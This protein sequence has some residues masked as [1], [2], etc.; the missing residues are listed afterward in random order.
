MAA[1][2]VRIR[3][4]HRPEPP[5]FFYQNLPPEAIALLATIPSRE[6]FAVSIPAGESSWR[7]GWPFAVAATEFAAGFVVVYKLQPDCRYAAVAVHENGRDYTLAEFIEIA[8]RRTR[9]RFGNIE[10]IPGRYVYAAPDKEE[11]GSILRDEGYAAINP[12]KLS[13]LHP[14]AVLPSGGTELIQICAPLFSGDKLPMREP[15]PV[16]SRVEILTGNTSGLENLR[17]DFEEYL[18]ARAELAIVPDV[19]AAGFSEWLVC[20][21]GESGFNRW[22]FRPVMAFGERTEWWG[23]RGRRRTVHEGLDFVEGF[24]RDEVRLIPEGVPARAIASGEVVA[25]LD[26]FMG[27]TIVV[28]HPSPTLSGGEVFHTILSHIQT[29]GSPPSFI[30]KGGML[31]RVGRRAGVRIRPHLHIT[32]AWF[33]SDFPFVEAGIDTIMHPG[34]T[35]IIL[36]DLNGLIEKSP[37]CVM[38]PDDR[39][40]LRDG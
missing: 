12:E 14:A 25:V 21:T 18:K 8:I 36:A 39:E 3:G 33:P 26:D 20:L 13:K 2:N 28:R 19:I 22:R 32:G 16:F 11:C 5:E 40:F 23:Q 29:E 10:R 17:L 37:L 7:G 31:G 15:L 34:F 30:K 9:D 38:S 24:S 27:K 4:R 1:L 35:Q 6:E